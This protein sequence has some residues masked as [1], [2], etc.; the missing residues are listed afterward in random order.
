MGPVVNSTERHDLNPDP[1]YCAKNQS[2]F[3]LLHDIDTVWGLCGKQIW[4]GKCPQ[5]PSD[6][7]LLDLLTKQNGAAS[8]T[9][10]EW[11]NLNTNGQ[12]TLFNPN[13]GGIQF[14]EYTQHMYFKHA[15]LQSST[16][17]PCHK[18]VTSFMFCIFIF[19]S[20]Q[21]KKLK[22]CIFYLLAD[23]FFPKTVLTVK[24]HWFNHAF[25]HTSV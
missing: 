8:A 2:L 10:L 22:K 6:L 15:S 11:L 13:L 19:K 9:Y 17:R 7:Q 16:G 20:T 5:T 25:M 24:T 23:F 18:Y 14:Q 21:V 1:I 12:R 3:L 4:A